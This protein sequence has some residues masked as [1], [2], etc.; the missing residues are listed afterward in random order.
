MLQQDPSVALECPEERAELAEKLV[1]QRGPGGGLTCELSGPLG[2]L[3]GV[4]G[5]EIGIRLRFVSFF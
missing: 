2:E 1:R 5:E 3:S 4:A